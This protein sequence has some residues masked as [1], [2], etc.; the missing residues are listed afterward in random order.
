MSTQLSLLIADFAAS[1]IAVLWYW[2]GP[3]IDLYGFSS[4]RNRA[5]AWVSRP[6]SAISYFNDAVFAGLIL[7]V[8]LFLIMSLALFFTRELMDRTS[9]QDGGFI[10]NAFYGDLKRIIVKYLTLLFVIVI[11]P[12]YYLYLWGLGEPFVG[13]V[14]AGA[15]ISFATFL[16]MMLSIDWLIIIILP[17]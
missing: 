12:Y 8:V 13:F 9:N 3:W 15:L 16:L 2:G 7:F 4:Y 17:R 14:S 6:A 11:L 1:L 10:Y 5:G